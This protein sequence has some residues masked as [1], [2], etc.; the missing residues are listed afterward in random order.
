M[1]TKD[2]ERFVARQQKTSADTKIDWAQVRKEWIQALNSLHVKIGGF[3]KD[4]TE[5]GSISYSFTEI[6]LNEPELGTYL[7]KR[8]DINIGRQHIS[9]VPIGTLL[10]GCKGR[11]DAEGPM[12]LAQILLVSEQAKS[13]ADL[14]RVTVSVG[15]KLPPS[16][17]EQKVTMWAWK[18]LTKTAE[19]RFVD[20]TKDSFFDL[21][22]EVANA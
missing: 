12:G 8:M 3:L 19:R 15:G 10:I 2:F 21:L 20:L 9:L 4:Y 7:A 6:E 11:V 5:A 14:I 16:S 22:M 13:A 1:E 17:P 18:I